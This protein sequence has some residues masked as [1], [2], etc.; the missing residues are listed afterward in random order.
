MVKYQFKIGDIVEI[1]GSFFWGAELVA[2][3]IVK[4]TSLNA[5]I[6]SVYTSHALNRPNLSYRDVTWSLQLSAIKPMALSSLEKL[7]YNID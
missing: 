6:N 3:D 1:T 2:G 7:I 4:I 5:E